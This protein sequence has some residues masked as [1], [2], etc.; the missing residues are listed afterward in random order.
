[1]PFGPL[2]M[3]YGILTLLTLL[4]LL[5]FLGLRGHWSRAEGRGP[6]VGRDIARTGRV[7]PPYLSGEIYLNKPP[8]FHS[9]VAASFKVLGESRWAA[10]LPTVLGSLLSVLLI[11]A[12][13]RRQG[14]QRAAFASGALLL[15][16]I[17]FHQQSRVCEMET[18]LGAS[19]LLLYLCLEPECR[20]IWPF[21]GA[22]IGAAGATLL[23]GPLLA[24]LFP[25]TFVLVGLVAERRHGWWRQ[26]ALLGT[27]VGV[28]GATAG[29]Y[30]PLYSDPEYR[31]MLQERL[32]MGNVSHVRPVT[33]YVQTLLGGLAPGLLLALGAGRS[34]R[35]V[36][37]GRSRT[38]LLAGLALL[39]IFA[40]FP[41]KQAHYLIPLLPLLLS[42]LGVALS[43][44]PLRGRPLIASLCGLFALLALV[45]PFLPTPQDQP[46]QMSMYCLLTAIVSGAS[47]YGLWVQGKALQGKP[48]SSK[49]A[50]LVAASL[51]MTLTVADGV[52]ALYKNPSRDPAIA[53]DH[54]RGEMKGRAIASLDRHPAVLYEVKRDTRIVHSRDEV[55]AFFQDRPGGR[56]LLEWDDPLPVSGAFAGFP[57]CATWRSADNEDGW[58]L[59]GAPA[60]A[61]PDVVVVGGTSAGCIAAIACR[62][63]GASVLLLE[64]GQ[65]LGGLS[66]SGLG[67]TDIGNKRA[68]GGLSREFYRRIHA[69]YSKSE[70][71]RW[72]DRSAFSGYAPDQDTM[73]RFEP[74]VA[75]LVFRDW[76]ADSGVPYRLGAALD[77][78]GPADRDPK[79]GQ[80]TAIRLK[81][82]T[83]IRAKVFIDATY[84]GDLMPLAKIPYTVGREPSSRYGESLNGIRKD[85]A[86]HH[87][88]EFPVSPYVDA[89]DPQSGLLP[90]IE[91]IGPLQDGDGDDRLQAFNFRVCLTDHPDNRI[92]FRK[93][94]RY[95][96]QNYELLFRHFEAGST[97]LP[98]HSIAMPGRKTDT[99]NNGAVSTDFI[100]GNRGYADATDKDRV[101]MVAE[102]RTWQEGL[103]WSLANHP[104]VPTNIREQ[105][106]KW[107]LSKDEFV[108]NDH[109]PHQIYV[110]EARRMMGDVV[111][112]QDHCNG[113]AQ[114]ED[115]IG[116]AAYNMD[117][118]HVRR[119]VDKQG[120]VRN[121][122]DVQ[123]APRE[124]YAISY[125]AIVAPRGSAGNVLVTCA[126]SASHIAYGSIRMEPVFMI[127]GHAAGCAAALAVH[128]GVTPQEIE[129]SQLRS[130]LIKE[131]QV[132]DWPG[133]E[134]RPKAVMIKSLDGIV[135]DDRDAVFQ[136]EWWPS[137]STL[138]HVGLGYRHDGNQNKG[139][140][141]ATFT[142]PINRSGRYELWF[143]YSAGGNRATNTKVVITSCEGKTIRSVNQQAPGEVDRLWHLLGTFEFEQSAQ[144]L[145]SNEGSDGHVIVDA[146]RLNPVR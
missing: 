91:D 20:G 120:H 89:G 127:L 116:L 121:E 131:Q 43:R 145:I 136:G 104:R 70:P 137:Q 33:F 100:G 95:Q 30:G 119:Y 61:D 45:V 68:I 141:T 22:M 138:P 21:L 14:G 17:L 24:L 83:S 41:S 102:H 74:H 18:L 85:R 128:Q 73:W 75:E 65:H 113:K 125:R 47:A 1:M 63:Q 62:L 110:R 34:L 79:T 115:P 140:A 51:A 99:N 27:L 130:T 108:D 57:V 31:T 90:S 10:R 56:V 139:W 78:T 23:K 132:L 109:W 118:H 15:T 26:L 82:G 32:A 142:A 13:A 94:A 55:M 126:V 98:W 50:V 35:A 84:E 144:V 69:Y 37:M 58:V 44:A 133:P 71:W 9:M 54:L 48:W 11:A 122:G 28:A 114:V 93:P 76:L 86:Q 96:E 4:V 38:H 2:T 143:G 117:S 111:M 52:I 72:E 42:P 134:P 40:A 60:Q 3:K 66:S 19:V 6:L 124:P 81:D 106:S 88:F 129:Y 80:L 59:L 112:T 105:A 16:G 29:Y 123:V 146:I 53:L 64:S 92:P 67:A 49:E 77:R 97:K 39:G 101:L 5:P 12:F 135:V 25:L 7:Q 107:G 103:L 46:T 8:L 36:F 87:Q